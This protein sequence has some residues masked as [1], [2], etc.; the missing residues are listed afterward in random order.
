[1]SPPPASIEDLASLKKQRFFRIPQQR[2]D[3]CHPP[4]RR[5]KLQK[6]TAENLRPVIEEMVADD[7]HA[8]TDSSTVLAGVLKARNQNHD[9]VNHRAKEYVRYEDGVCI[10]TKTIEG[11]F[12]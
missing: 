12:S 7:A 11:H 4:P 5:S 9:Q 6:V 1:M 8:M 10:T 3:L 2:T